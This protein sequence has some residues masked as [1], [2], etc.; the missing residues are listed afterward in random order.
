MSLARKGGS[1]LFHDPTGQGFIT[2]GL[3]GHRETWPLVSRNVREWL[4]RKYY[5]AHKTSPGGDALKN[6][7][8]T[9]GGIATFDG[10]CRDV[11]VRARRPRGRRL[12]GP[13]H[14]VL[15]GRADPRFG[16]GRDPGQ[17]GAGALP[18]AARACSPLPR[19]ESG[20][21]L[22]ALR[23][24]INVVD[25]D[26]FDL[27]V[28][29]LVGALNPRGTYPILVFSG[30]QGSAK[31]T[32]ARLTRACLDPNVA[33][34][35]SQPR[36]EG[37]VL[38]AASNGLVVGY[39]N[40]SK[41]PDWLSD[42]LC[43]LTSGG[44]VG[45]RQLFTDGDEFILD[46]RRPALLTGIESVLSRGDAIDRALLVELQ[47]M[48]KGQRRTEAAVWSAFEEAHAG[49]LG[50]LLDAASTA[51]REL[52]NTHIDE[53]PRLADFACWVEAAAPALGWEQ[54]R[55]LRVYSGNRDNADEVAIDAS[56]IGPT[57]RGFLAELGEGGVWEGTASELLVKLNERA[58]DAAK[59]EQ[60]WP[61]RANSLSGQVKRLAP[62]LRRIGFGVRTGD[63]EGHERRRVIRLARGAAKHR[64]HRPQDGDGA[65]NP[66][67]N[68]DFG[69]ESADD[70]TTQGSSAHR[71]PSSAHRPHGEDAAG[72]NPQQRRGF[73]GH[74]AGCGRCGRCGRCFAPFLG[75]RH[76]R[77]ARTASRLCRVPRLSRGH[78]RRRG[79]VPRVR[80]EGDVMGFV[81]QHD[82]KKRLR[83][84]LTCDR[85][86]REI[87]YR[88]A[89]KAS[90]VAPP[91]SDARGDRAR[92]HRSG[93]Y[94]RC[95]EGSLM[96]ELCCPSC[97]A[98]HDT[99]R[100][101]PRC[102][103]W[104]NSGKHRNGRPAR[105]RRRCRRL[106]Q[107]GIS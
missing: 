44:G 50:A 99:R 15:G 6:A 49:I 17:R 105:R 34:L 46:A 103:R 97:Q 11:F 69:A 66:H 107:G 5:E 30:E 3:N 12:P 89:A 26:G 33:P 75:E 67:D 51:L 54:G 83:V 38:I 43:R 85:C 24:L 90:S 8:T 96:I 29:W 93:S 37:D 60:D 27:V 25:A 86:G 7:L 98:P 36:E 104:P 42:A 40:L 18:A 58:S 20:G 84:R 2:F 23:G 106:G 102:G 91:R 41:L 68:A 63:R 82:D 35:R 13:R 56:A 14:P 79:V 95:L 74:R 71:P 28:G 100:A 45:K 88:D 9:L 10:A 70:P 57:L 65:G 55:F 19:P 31:T 1:D 61:K 80:S 4:S 16:V 22:S 47:T 81:A 32:A 72:E 53:L 77:P 39:D 78:R 64:P 101:C 62:H 59:K 21:D 76:R 94:R 48:A 92:I 73:F 52:P 87:D